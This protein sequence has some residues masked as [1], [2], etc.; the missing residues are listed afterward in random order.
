AT[1]TQAEP[2]IIG[3]SQGRSLEA[4]HPLALGQEQVQHVLKAAEE[5][6]RQGTAQAQLQQAA[7]A[8]CRGEVG[9]MRQRVLEE[10]GGFDMRKAVH[11]PVSLA[12]QI[13]HRLVRLGTLRIVI[14]QMLDGG[15]KVTAVAHL[16]RPTSLT[17]QP[18]AV[19]V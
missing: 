13:L 14:R 10:R 18:L 17:M 2:E 11:C 6:E 8:V 5:T 4:F 16:Q 15:L 9:G 7:L 1:A 12:R 3:A 19:V